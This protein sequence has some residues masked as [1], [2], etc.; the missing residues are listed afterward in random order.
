VDHICGIA[1]LFFELVVYSLLYSC[2]I[3]GDFTR[4][5]PS[6][7][8]ICHKIVCVSNCGFNGPILTETKFATTSSHFSY[9]ILLKLQ[10]YS[11][12]CEERRTAT[13]ATTSRSGECL[14]E[15]MKAT[16]STCHLL[17]R[18]SARSILDN[19]DGGDI[20]LRNV[21]SL[22][23]DTRRYISEDSTLHHHRCENLKCYI[24]E[25]VAGRKTRSEHGK[26]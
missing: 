10:E 15:S 6:N 8:C 16:R 24:Q 3:T 17:S 25:R 5:L 11:W 13:T 19:E 4:S 26:S 21:G 9:R 14:T 12:T 18:I 1:L 23:A 22:S 20:F 2:C 7:G